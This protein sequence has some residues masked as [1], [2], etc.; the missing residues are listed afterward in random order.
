MKT[1]WADWLFGSALSVS[2]LLAIFGPQPCRI[3]TLAAVVGIGMLYSVHVLYCIY[4]DQ[5]RHDEMERRL[6]E[7]RDRH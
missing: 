7:R 2:A 5:R 1:A 3:G 6:A 4:L